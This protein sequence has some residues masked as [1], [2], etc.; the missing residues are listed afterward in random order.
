MD[1]RIFEIDNFFNDPVYVR[2][3]GLS[4]NYHSCNFL[5]SNTLYPGYRTIDVQ[6]DI[7]EEIKTK[8]ENIINQKSKKIDCFYSIVTH[9]SM[10]GVPHVDPMTKFAGLIYL[11]LHA[12]H[13]SGTTIYEN[14]YETDFDRCPPELRS[15]FEIL[16]NVSIRPSNIIK[17]RICD[18]LLEMKNSLT[19]KR[20]IDSKFNRAVIYDGSQLHSADNYFGDKKENGRMTINFFSR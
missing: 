20:K 9:Q 17:K 12:T 14:P 3:C 5:S 10:F 4:L 1:E 7:R 19:V 11:N 15:K 18:E 8:L 6:D 2:N 16:Y 13:N